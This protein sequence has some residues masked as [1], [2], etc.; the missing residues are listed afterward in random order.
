MHLSCKILTDNDTRWTN[1]IGASD[2][3]DSPAGQTIQH[4]TLDNIIL[5]NIMLFYIIPLIAC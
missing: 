1:C 2:E 4:S 5:Y 3:G